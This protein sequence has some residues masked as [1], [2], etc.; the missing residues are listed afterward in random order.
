[1]V[2]QGITLDPVEVILTT[3]TLSCRYKDTL[4]GYSPPGG[5]D[6]RCNRSER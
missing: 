2:H 3:Q 4:S 5:R 1:M 6:D